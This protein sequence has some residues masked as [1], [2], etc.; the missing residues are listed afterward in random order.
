MRNRSDRIIPKQ[1]IAIAEIRNDGDHQKNCV[2]NYVDYQA[3]CISV[4]AD[5]DNTR[6]TFEICMYQDNKEICDDVFSGRD[7]R[8]D[9]QDYMLKNKTTAAFRLLEEK[10][11]EITVPSYI[12]EAI[13]WIS[14]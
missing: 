9:P 5:I 13:E 8:L 2:D 7:I 3:D 1:A 11:N 4:Y 12:R 10:A 6:T 14:G